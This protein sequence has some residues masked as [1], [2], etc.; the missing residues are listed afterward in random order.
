MPRRT[1]VE[2]S[3]LDTE[4]SA[5]TTSFGGTA[6]TGLAVTPYPDH[7]TLTWAND[8]TADHYEVWGSRLSSG[9]Y[10]KLGTVFGN[11]FNHTRLTEIQTF[12]YKVRG[13]NGT[14]PGT[15]NT[16]IQATTTKNSLT[17][18]RTHLVNEGM[19][20][21]I[22]FSRPIL[23]VTDVIDGIEVVKETQSGDVEVTIMGAHRRGSGG[24][25]SRIVDADLLISPSTVDAPGPRIKVSYPA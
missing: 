5:F 14:T 19:R 4:V 1:K 16:P 22:E 12:W 21:V 3:A 6:P 11:T 18:V 17:M 8:T 2:V 24:R 7:V 25:D 20:V 13:S 9:T 10:T 23:P 15:F